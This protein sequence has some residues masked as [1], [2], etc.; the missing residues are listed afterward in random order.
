MNDSTSTELR[1]ARMRSF[2]NGVLVGAI[3][4]AI[5]ELALRWLGLSHPILYVKDSE[6]GYRL[7]PSQTVTYGRNAISINRWGVR[8]SRA[9]DAKDPDVRRV[10][11]LGDSVTW[12][13]VRERQDDLFTS[14]LEERLSGAEVINAGV[15]GYSIGQMAAL[16][17]GNLRALAPDLVVV[18]AIVR[19]FTRPPKVE[20]QGESPLFPTRKPSWALPEAMD[21]AIFRLKD[22]FGL[23]AFA[24][25]VVW[26]GH[27]LNEDQCVE[28]NADALKG[29]AAELASV[30]RLLVVLLPDQYAPDRSAQA[31]RIAAALDARRIPWKDLAPAVPVRADLFIDRVHLTRAGHEEIAHALAPLVQ[32]SLSHDV[33]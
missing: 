19:D 6:A 5:L 16:Y 18:C 33:R 14:R 7:K 22:R 11:I 20:L 3:A 23:D 28:A 9:F 1:F 10:L 4:L 13:G 27:A 26:A 2:R 30:A 21:M 31:A 25:P 8:D 32:D 15:N 29:L 12:G 17:R 24:Y